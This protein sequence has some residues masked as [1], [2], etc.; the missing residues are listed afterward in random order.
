MNF[1]DYDVLKKFGF[2]E[3]INVKDLIENS[4]SDVPNQ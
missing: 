2:S 1:N 3:F 4:C